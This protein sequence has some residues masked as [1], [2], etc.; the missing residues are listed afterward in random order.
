MKRIFHVALRELLSTVFTKGFILGMLMTPVLIGIALVAL[1]LLMNEAPPKIDGEL[2]VVDP[3]GEVSA[4]VAEYLDPA[5][6]A[7][8]RE[9]LKQRIDEVMPNAVKSFTDDPKTKK[10]LDDA[11]STAAGDVPV[12]SVHVL[13]DD[14]DLEAEKA[15]LLVGTA[16]DGGRLA[17]VVVHDNAVVADA[18]GGY[19]KFDLYVREK[20]DDRIVDE[21]RDAFKETIIARRVRGQ[22]LDL[23]EVKRLTRVGR[24]P[25]RTVTE[26]GERENTEI[27]NMFLPMAFMILLLMSVM[28][29]GQYLM[30]TT[31]EEKSSRVVEVLLAAVSPMELMTGKVL[32]QLVVGFIVLGLYGGLGMVGL[33]SFSMVGLLD[34]MLLVYLVIFYL[35]AYFVLA[36]FMAA[37]G[38]AVN[39]MREAQT[40]MTPIILVVMIPWMLWLPIT[41]N[42]DSLFAVVLSFVP[43]LSSFVM[44]IRLASTSPPPFWQVAASIA[45][46]LV[47]VYASLVLAAKVFRIGLLLHGKPPNFATLVRWVRMA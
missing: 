27:L 33:L 7:Q 9:E 25:T 28:T 11:I 47:A 12:I 13:P 40:L 35:T 46:G 19:G 23:D 10:A 34:P 39:E 3:T 41:R 36:S 42:P 24:V 15:P 18:E 22:G 16:Q 32:G 44:M 17:L 8:R 30:T 26:E 43:P 31:I 4:G 37:V 21:I 5:A 6:V 45:V 1:P 20:L 14:A 38:A 29:G 2:A